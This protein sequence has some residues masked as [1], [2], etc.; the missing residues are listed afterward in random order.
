VTWAACRWWYGGQVRALQRA[1]SSEASDE[2]GHGA[3]REPDFM[4]SEPSSRSAGNPRALR[5]TSLGGRPVLPF[6]ETSPLSH[7]AEPEP[8][9]DLFA[10]FAESSGT[11]GAGD[12]PYLN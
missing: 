7:L 4:P 1:L 12:R 11:T 6:L 9:P 2:D 8:E 5:L 10:H 3:D